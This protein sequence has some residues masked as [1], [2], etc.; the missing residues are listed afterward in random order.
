MC[1]PYRRKKHAEYLDMA[2]YTVIIEESDN[3][4]AAYLPELPGCVAAGDTEEETKTLIREA[5]ME[6][7]ALLAGGDIS[8]QIPDLQLS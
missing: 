1:L 5:V 2:T 8:A 6:H 4:Y 3:G 7:L